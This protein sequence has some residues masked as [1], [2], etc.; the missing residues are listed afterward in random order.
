MLRA[1][2]KP[3]DGKIIVCAL[4]INEAEA[5]TKLTVRQ[6]EAQPLAL[7]AIAICFQDLFDAHGTLLST[8]AK[9]LRSVPKTGKPLIVSLRVAVPTIAPGGVEKTPP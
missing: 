5:I 8:G 7:I 3:D 4:L 6:K 1:P 2:G 9:Y